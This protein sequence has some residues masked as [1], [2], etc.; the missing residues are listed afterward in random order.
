MPKI[1]RAEYNNAKYGDS[2]KQVTPG[3]YIVQIQ[4]VR[5]SWDDMDWEQRKR[6][7][8]SAD[9][10][11]CVMFVYDIAEGE[12]AGEYSRDFYMDGR[13]DL[14]SSKDFMHWVKYSW[15]DLKNLKRFDD[16]LRASN[17]GFDPEAAFDADRWELYVG[18]KFGV[19]I[20]GTVVTSERG[21]DQW[22]LRV[23]P[24]KVRSIEQIHDGD[25]PEPY[26]TDKRTS[27]PQLSAYDTDSIPF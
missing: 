15:D 18:K 24:W 22:R 23:K 14:D 2:F 16:A 8:F 26:I 21:Y 9:T 11:Q 13:G 7:E 20:D 25:Y 27:E 10:D 1:N 17:P 4:A 5:T 6:R 3:A 19:V 12:L